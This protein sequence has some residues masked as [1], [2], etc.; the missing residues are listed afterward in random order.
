[1]KQIGRLLVAG[2]VAVAMMGAAVAQD[3]PAPRPTHAFLVKFGLKDKEA[4]KWDGSV[5]LS[6]GRVI[7]V[8]GW[9]F[10]KED[11]ALSASS[12]QASTRPKVQRKL[13]PDELARR[14]GRP[15][16]PPPIIPNGVIITVAAP[17][18]AVAE[19]KL[20]QGNFSVKLSDLAWGKRLAQLQG[21]ASVERVTIT[22][23]VTGEPRHEDWADAVIGSNGQLYVCYTSYAD[24]ADDVYLHSRLPTGRWW[25]EPVRLTTESG[26]NFEP[27]IAQDGE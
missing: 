9:H 6:A 19:V 3:Q 8:E 24:E 5:S 21:N 15:L 7:K 11:K 27:Q 23:R 18:E 14:G 20:A 2:I 10:D 4:T 13:R 12:W 17:A 26:D 25:A 1:M 22:E 16:P